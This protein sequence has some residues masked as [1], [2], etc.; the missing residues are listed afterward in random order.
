MKVEQLREQIS[1][2]PPEQLRQLGKELLAVDRYRRGELDLGGFAL[3]AGLSSLAEAPGVLRQY[4]VEPRPDHLITLE[5]ML[6]ALKSGALDFAAKED[7]LYTE[8]D[9]QERYR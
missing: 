9:L 6:A 4:G 7:D 1:A 2:L 8:A 3:E 5:G